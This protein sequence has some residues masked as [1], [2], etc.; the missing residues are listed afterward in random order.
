MDDV[1]QAIS[2]TAERLSRCDP[3]LDQIHLSWKKRSDAE[4][5]KLI[6][7]LLAHPDVVAKV[8]M[9]GNRL[10]DETGVK[11]AQYVTASSTVQTLCL[12]ANPIT[13]T[14]YLAMATALRVNSSLQ[15]LSLFND[16]T[17]FSDDEF[18]PKDYIVDRTL[19]DG[20]FIEALRLNPNRPVDSCWNLYSPFEN[21]FKRLKQIA[22]EMDHVTPQMIPN[23]ELEKKSKQ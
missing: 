17:L 7:C 18:V 12:F 3:T 21:D 9:C 16:E 10:T 4:L 19:I 6:D 20:E 15:I 11:L 13:M 14:T 23:H 1:S 8:R 22:D 2:E 5:T